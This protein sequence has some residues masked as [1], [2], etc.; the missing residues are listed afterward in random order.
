MLK[1]KKEEENKPMSR[2]RRE[3]EMKRGAKVGIQSKVEE[4]R[5]RMWRKCERWREDGDR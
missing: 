1:R 2:G 4:G 5:G 3:K